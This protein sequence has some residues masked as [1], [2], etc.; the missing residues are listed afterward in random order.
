MVPPISEDLIEHSFIQGG[1]LGYSSEGE[2][3]MAP[4]QRVLV[5][6]KAAGD[7]LAKQA[8]D[9]DLAL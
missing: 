8:H 3:D 2:V 7:E 1:S 6:K 9:P 4:R 5:K